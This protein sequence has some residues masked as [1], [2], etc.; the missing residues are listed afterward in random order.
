[1]LYT[2]KWWGAKV[3]RHYSSRKGGF[4]TFSRYTNFR[5]MKTFNSCVQKYYCNKIEPKLKA[6]V[7]K[8]RILTFFLFCYKKQINSKF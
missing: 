4:G 5:N 7:S 3:I 1:M 2:M 6:D 8:F